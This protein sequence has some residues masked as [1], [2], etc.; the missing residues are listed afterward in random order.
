MAYAGLGQ[1]DQAIR[2]AQAA[3]ELAPQSAH[4]RV[5]V[6]GLL[7][8]SGRFADAEE[9]LARAVQLAPDNPDALFQLGVARYSLGRRDEAIA[10][11]RQA[12][13]ANGSF[14]P[15]REALKALRAGSPCWSCH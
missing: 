14:R 5:M 13:Q 11:F 2:A 7:N 12:L 9:Q 8:R 15:A 3:V 1:T 10:A 6:G 4:L